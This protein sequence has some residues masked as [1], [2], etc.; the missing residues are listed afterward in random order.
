MIIIRI[1]NIHDKP[2]AAFY[3]DPW[4]V[5]A[6]DGLDLEI[7]NDMC[8]VRFKTSGTPIKLNNPERRMNHQPSDGIFESLRKW[9]QYLW[10]WD[11]LSPPNSVKLPTPELYSIPDAVIPYE[12]E[13]L[14]DT[15]EYIRILE[16][17]P[18]EGVGNL[19]GRFLPVSLGNESPRPEYEAISYAWGSRIAPFSLRLE[20]GRTMLLTAS[21]YLG[22]RKILARSDNA[23]KKS[24]YIW[25]DALCIDQDEKKPEKAKQIRMLPEIF[26]AA[27]TVNAWLGEAEEGSSKAMRALN[28]WGKWL[29]RYKQEAT[30]DNPAYTWQL[31]DIK[32]PVPPVED[33]LW[34]HISRLLSRKWFNRLW[35][36]QEVVVAS[37][38]N[39]MCGTEA[40]VPWDTFYA[41]AYYCFLQEKW[42]K[43]RDLA[44]GDEKTRANILKLG[45]LRFDSHSE[46]GKFQAQHKML[47]LLLQCDHKDV[48]DPRDRMFGTISMATDAHRE[49]L[50]PNYN[51]TAPQVT[52]NY[53]RFFVEQG[54]AFE[55]LYRTR[56]K[57][58]K[59][60]PEHMRA[61]DPALPSW[62][63]DLTGGHYPKSLSTWNE[64]RFNAGDGWVGEPAER[65]T[66]DGDHLLIPGYIVE[67][68]SS[69]GSTASN[70]GEIKAYLREIFSA[71][72]RAYKGRDEQEIENV[73]SRLPIGNAAQPTSGN[74]TGEWYDHEPNATDAYHALQDFLSPGRETT[75]SDKTQIERMKAASGSRGGFGQHET[76]YRRLWPYIN[77]TKD[78]ADVFWPDFAVVCECEVKRGQGRGEDQDPPRV[79]MVPTSALPGDVVAVFPGARVPFVLRGVQGQ[80]TFQLI[81]ECYID[82]IMHGEAV[83]G[84]Q[85]KKVD[86]LSIRLV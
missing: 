78:F 67:I 84:F 38:L 3:V 12:W 31:P 26:K 30:S 11:P 24:I 22:L 63:P 43:E 50:Q 5:Y 1:F 39:V 65:E 44:I 49:E 35:I 69:V 16:L 41:G 17:L 83:R 57:A 75:T 42:R 19:H 82:G 80:G 54:D 66:L 27:K 32:I 8:E 73:K 21:L 81:G 58:R 85:E 51:L 28:D 33:P 79:G 64:C 45:E 76:L 60:W 25:A 29:L 72:D 74:A 10:G 62:I 52:R 48:T 77:T 55:L 36:V 47:D 56:F 68:I 4:D 15:G 86:I 34:G 59:S 7:R 2:T 13:S 20:Q 70:S 61:A 71:V 37:D 46:H 53:A 6:R 40:P 9:F 14:P 23:N 18:L